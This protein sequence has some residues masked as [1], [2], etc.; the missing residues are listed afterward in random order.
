MSMANG[1]KKQG[2]RKGCPY[3]TTNGPAKPVYSSG[4]ACPCHS[5]PIYS[6]TS[7]FANTGPCGRPSDFIKFT[8]TMTIVRFPYES[9][10]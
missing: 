4:R 1:A 3:H 9:T 6:L 10:Q 2:N 8:S 7:P 5:S